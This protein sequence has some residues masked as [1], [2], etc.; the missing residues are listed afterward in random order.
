MK[1]SQ[2]SIDGFVPRRSSRQLGELHSATAIKKK[3]E[4]LPQEL[5]LGAQSS[6]GAV[7]SARPQVGV[8]RTA[9]DESLRDIDTPSEKLGRRKDRRRTTGVVGLSRR[10]KIIKWVAI[11]VVTIGFLVGGY[12]GYKA[13]TT[14]NKIFKGNILSLVQNQPLKKD[15]NGRSNFLILG[16]TDDDPAHPGGDLTDSMMVV[17]IDQE[18]KNAY[19]FSVPRDLYVEYGMACTSGYEGKIN[20]YFSCVSDGATDEEEMNRLQQTQSLI[21]EIFGLDIQYGVH[22]NSAVLPEAVNAVGGIDVDI[23]G[24]NG[25]PGVLDRNFDAQCNYKC[26]KVKYD[27]GVHHLNGEQ[28]SYLS[29][30]RGS[31]SP[32]YGLGNSNFDR[33]KN[34]QKIL[35]ALKEK[36]TSTG[37]LTNI[38]AVTGLLDTLGDN[39]RTNVDTSELRTLMQL[40]AELKSENIKQLSFY[41]DEEGDLMATGMHGGG[42]A[43]VPSEGVFEYDQIRKYITKKLTSDPVMQ[44]SATIS[45]FNGSGVAGVAQAEADKLESLGMMIAEVGNAAEGE[46]GKAKIYQVGTGMSAT[47][48]K[49][50][51]IYGV[52]IMTETPP[53]TVTGDTNFVVSVGQAPASQSQ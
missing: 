36:A 14:G 8:F 41:G 40:G 19:M 9:I 22:I 49:L 3:N 21:G 46:Y 16:T 31:V 35:I 15:A 17:S 38:G 45:V 44:E 29:M 51:S 25:A 2:H 28:A 24:S 7:I 50:E 20:G 34:Q 18:K 47:K 13:L 33:E 32:T 6:A 27:N 23:Q 26:Y 37:T 1:K 11:G 52:K 42:S 48:A 12:L 5:H 4:A 10:R 43:V 30:A 39:L 53:V